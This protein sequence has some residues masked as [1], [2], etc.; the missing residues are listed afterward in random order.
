MHQL[1]RD[2]TG[3]SFPALLQSSVFKPLGMTR[4]TFEQPL[5]AAWA[6]NAARAHRGNGTRISGRWHIYPELAPDGLWTTPSDLAR[7]AIEIQQSLRGQSNKVLSPEM[8]KQMLTRQLRSMGLGIVVNGNGDGDALRARRRERGIPLSL[9]RV[10]FHGTR[11]R[12]HDKCR[13]RRGA[14]A[15]NRT[16]HRNRVRLAGLPARRAQIRADRTA[17]SG[18]VCRHLSHTGRRTNREHSRRGR[19]ARGGRRRPARESDR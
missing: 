17:G 10:R 19:L 9:R 15:G 11:L 16:R 12:R 6:T 2:V 8:T 18:G 5:P 4:S 3:D 1:V 13:Q 14:R 7:F